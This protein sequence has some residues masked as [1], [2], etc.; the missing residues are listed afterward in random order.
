ME[1]WPVSHRSLPIRLAPLVIYYVVQIITHKK[2]WCIPDSLVQ[3][4]RQILMC[5]PPLN[6]SDSQNVS[7]DSSPCEEPDEPC[8]CEECVYLE[9]FYSVLESVNLV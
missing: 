4:A 8:D 6:Y 5:P 7:K 2:A 3:N 9:A 1:D